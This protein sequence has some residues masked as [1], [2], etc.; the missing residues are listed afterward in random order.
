MGNKLM[1][2]ETAAWSR[3]AD[4]VD[5][6]HC[7]YEKRDGDASLVEKWANE[8]TW[9]CS[10]IESFKEEDKEDKYDQKC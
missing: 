5:A 3:I 8:I 1:S 6:I 2:A 7:E 4:L 10:I 9:Q